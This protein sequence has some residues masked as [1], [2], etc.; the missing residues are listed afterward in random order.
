MAY[1][2]AAD[3]DPL[4]PI[5]ASRIQRIIDNQE[6]HE[7][8]IAVNEVAWVDW[9]PSFSAL[10]VGSGTLIAR[11]RT[12]GK[13]VQ[14]Y[15][16]FTYGAGSSVGTNPSFTLP[17]TPRAS[18]YSNNA[19]GGSVIGQANYYNNTL[20]RWYPA[21]FVRLSAAATASLMCATGNVTFVSTVNAVTSSQPFTWAAAAKICVYGEYEID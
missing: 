12:I 14:Y 19:S 8:R 4:D 18:T 6:D 7:T 11:H 3:V 10:T 17:S 5:V 2:K 15:L 13:T 21:G 9:T 20:T 1:V 16:E